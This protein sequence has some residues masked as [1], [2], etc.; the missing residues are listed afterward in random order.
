[1][2]FPLF[3]QLSEDCPR[4]KYKPTKSCDAVRKGLH[5]GQRKLL[6]SEI[7]FLSSL[8]Q[9]GPL[10]PLLVVYAGAANG[11]HLPKMFQLFP[12]AGCCPVKYILV[13]PAPFCRLVQEEAKRGCEGSVLEL[14]EGYCT[15]ELCQRIRSIYGAE[16]SLAFISDIRSGAP[17]RTQTNQEASEIVLRDNLL[18]AQCCESLAPQAAMLK[19]HPPYPPTSPEDT[20]PQKIL[21]YSGHLLWG[22]WAPRSS[23]EVRLV[24]EAPINASSDWWS[25]PHQ[26]DSETPPRFEKCPVEVYDGRAFEERCYFYNTSQRY[27]NDVKAERWILEEYLLHR[28][29]VK[30]GNDL[31]IEVA[32]LSNELSEFL[33]FPLLR[34]AEGAIFEELALKMPTDERNE[35]LRSGSLVAVKENGSCSVLQRF[36]EDDARV[37]AFLY[38]VERIELFNLLRPPAVTEALV[39]RWI[40]GDGEAAI[41]QEF[42]DLASV[43]SLTAFFNVAPATSSKILRNK[44][45]WRTGD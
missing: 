7:E 29:K 18:Q 15:P 39:H 27:E 33:G 32:H 34:F 44:K 28:R 6:L 9:R 37:S 3:R 40:A 13:D 11:S 20:S 2:H 36:T 10:K 5:F 43:Q 17:S 35:V 12:A 16:Y 41:P 31:H 45:R 42:I 4:R 38:D 23:T 19:F 30:P 25:P 26:L 21:Y 22:V 14:I 1:M 8:L 24:V